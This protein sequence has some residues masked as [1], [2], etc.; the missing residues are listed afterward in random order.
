M[1][2]DSGRI[3]FQAN[4]FCWLSMHICY[5]KLWFM[6]KLFFKKQ[7]F[8]VQVPGLFDMCVTASFFPSEMK[9]AEISPFSKEMITFAKK[10]TG[11]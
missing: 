1:I 6:T 4:I 2:N 8:V 9:L 11:L 7:L 3:F 10:I 5:H